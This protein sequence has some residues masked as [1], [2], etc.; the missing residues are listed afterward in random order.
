MNWKHLTTVAALLL[1]GVCGWLLWCF[2]GAAAPP[3]V[4]TEGGLAGARSG[5]HV[6]SIAPAQAVG[7][8]ADAVR[9]A[10]DE[11]SILGHVAFLDAASLE[12]ISP[13]RWLARQA[14]GE[15]RALPGSADG[16]L[17]LARAVWEFQPAQD[18][19][20]LEAKVDLRVEP[21]QIVWVQ[22]KLE[23]EII[24]TSRRD[25]LPIQ[26]ARIGSASW[27]S[28]GADEAEHG[29]RR[30]QWSSD[31]ITDA[32][33]RA[34]LND[35]QLPCALRVVAAGYEPLLIDIGA[36]DD[37]LRVA[38]DEA[39]SDSI[40][41]L[42]VD[43]E[44]GGPVGPIAVGSWCGGLELTHG[45][46][47]VVALKLPGTLS[48]EDRL[49]VEAEGY[50]PAVVVVDRLRGADG[51]LPKVVLRRLCTLLIQG[52][53]SAED[54]WQVWVQGA[55]EIG[56]VG[57]PFEDQFRFQDGP[58]RRAVPV[59][60]R[61]EVLG[62]TAKG[63]CHETSLDTH[64]GENVLTLGAGGP[65]LRLVLQSAASNRLVD[66]GGLRA[67][68][69]VRLTDGLPSFRVEA[70]GGELVIPHPS[71]VSNL[72]VRLAG[73]EAVRLRRGADAAVDP[74]GSIVLPLAIAHPVLLRVVDD[75]DRP[76]PGLRLLVT[77]AER[78]SS[79]R[80]T[81]GHGAWTVEVRSPVPVFT[82]GRGVA[83]LRLVEGAY[84][85]MVQLPREV[86]GAPGAI[87]YAGQ[88]VG[89]Q[90]S[91]AGEHR[92]VV[93]PPRKIAILATDGA[94][95]Q[96]LRKVLV[97]AA[98]IADLE[99]VAAL[100]RAIWVPRSCG[101]ITLDA[102]GYLT[103]SVDLHPEVPVAPV[104]MHAG[105]VGTLVLEG[106]HADTL[107]GATL[108]LRSRDPRGN[109]GRSVVSVDDP[110]AVRIELAG[111]QLEVSIDPAE[112]SDRRWRFEPVVSRWDAGG[113]LRFRPML[114]E[115]GK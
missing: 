11:E 75:Q 28:R 92:L 113:V 80:M 110:G 18:L 87:H 22:R 10:A 70:A 40:R 100:G 29:A 78:E 49:V 2:S 25:G 13:A 74:A 88:W 47:G 106:P 59:G 73:H 63:D 91:G 43:G 21:Q 35:L 96:P 15:W 97:R 36:V 76:V 37:P 4:H 64:P 99:P 83:S 115:V 50:A 61:L 84:L 108:V 67:T 98:G 68:A 46:E 72:S 1:V 14:G 9:V 5:A 45:G 57:L 102:P 111:A 32:L 105:G 34:R 8:A 38:M 65:Q 104:V 85:G 82:D 48:P 90:V 51:G 55:A 89:F 103:A 71:R 54:P 26:E 20:I 42:V 79:R 69:V 101:R 7:A 19:R 52:E 60:S 30:F 24:V 95:G 12:P 31:T 112:A 86:V 33:G 39:N 23:R 109:R 17:Q 62:R 81:T 114:E 6:G 16:V 44:S 93:D 53:A 107:R 66:V 3:S 41:M 58:A 56:G 77:G 94:T 27:S